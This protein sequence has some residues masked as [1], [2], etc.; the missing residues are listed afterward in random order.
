MGSPAHILVVDDEQMVREVVARYLEREGFRVTAVGDGQA[1]IRALTSSPDLIV[2]DLMLPK[3]DGLEVLRR[4]RASTDSA[5]LMLTARGTIDDRIT[6]LDLGADDY[7]AKPFSPRELVARVHAVLAPRRRPPA[8]PAT[9]TAAGDAALV[10]G[11]LVDRSRRSGGEARRAGARPWRRASST[12]CTT[13]RPTRA[14]SSAARIC[15]TPSGISPSTATRRPSPSTSAASARRS[16]PIPRPRSGS[17]PCAAPATGSSHE[18]P[19]PQPSR[20]REPGRDRD[21]ARRA[22]HPRL[23]RD[24]RHAGQGARARSPSPWS[25]PCCSRS[26]AAAVAAR[27]LA[28]AS[29]RQ[30]TLGV[31]AV[32]SIV[33]LANL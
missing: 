4:A 33:G 20:H 24:H 19:S 9:A 15:S 6:G 23:R 12:C 8:P 25:R 21:R 31:V 29:I 1:A 7:L 30:R 5:V 22:R 2:L 3:V 28:G 27:L 32:A 26:I 10:F 17:S 18:P 14:A 11:D 13:S 16:R